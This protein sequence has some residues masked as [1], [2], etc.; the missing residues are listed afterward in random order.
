MFR[1]CFDSDFLMKL[2]YTKN[3]VFILLG[4][5]L[6]REVSLLFYMNDYDPTHHFMDVRTNAQ[7]RK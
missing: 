6:K 5:I 3:Y 2:I 4:P 7:L 1:S